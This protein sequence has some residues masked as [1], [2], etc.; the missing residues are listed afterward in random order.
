MC[1]ATE[2]LDRVKIHEKS[3]VVIYDTIV[4][5]Q[6]TSVLYAFLDSWGSQ[7]EIDS[8]VAATSKRVFQLVSGISFACIQ[9]M[10]KAA[11]PDDIWK[12]FCLWFR[13]IIIQSQN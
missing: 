6:C 7:H 9:Q 5:F 4:V 8:P 13:M 2:E 1:V 10:D 12:M 3:S 11:F